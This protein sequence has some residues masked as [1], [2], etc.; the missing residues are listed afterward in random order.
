MKK[1]LLRILKYGLII[2]LLVVLVFSYLLIFHTYKEKTFT[3]N[4]K[5]KVIDLSN[6]D[7]DG[8]GI[9]NAADIIAN[10]RSLKGVFYEYLQGKYD[11]IGRKIGFLVCF[12]IPKIAYEK[13]GIDFEILLREDYKRHKEYYNSEKGNNTPSTSFFYRRTR[14]LYSYCKANNKLILNC[15]SPRP[16]DLI[17]YG[18][19]HIAIVTEVHNNG[20]YNE[21]ENAPWTIFTVEHKNK[22]W[23]PI[24]VG[25]I[26]EN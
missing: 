19:V 8:D 3:K 6:P 11:N 12:D 26:L 25:R 5:N 20:T 21:I 14:N 24:D 13:A 9:K 4:T 16:C 23:T 18:Q 10:A 1:I 15:N 17:F 7:I 22:K 2:L